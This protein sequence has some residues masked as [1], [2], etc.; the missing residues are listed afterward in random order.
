MTEGT[1]DYNKN[2]IM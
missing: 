1:G 2:M